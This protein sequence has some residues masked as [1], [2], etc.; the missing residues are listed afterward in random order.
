MSI[1][2]TTADKAKASLKEVQKL[3][4]ARTIEEDDIAK[5][6]IEAERELEKRLYKKDWDGITAKYDLHAQSFPSAYKGVPESTVVKLQRTRT[7]W[8]V[9]VYRGFTD[10]RQLRISY[11]EEKAAAMLAFARAQA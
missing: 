1:K 6:I 11:P 4:R 5:A 7:S 8:K 3:S 10:S 2:Y 9:A